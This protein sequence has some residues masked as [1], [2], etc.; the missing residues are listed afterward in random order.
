M[1]FDDKKLEFNKGVVSYFTHPQSIYNK[2]KANL[3][4]S[5]RLNYDDEGEKI[6]P[7]DQIID[8][9]DIASI[10]MVLQPIYD[11]YH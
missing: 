11:D 5:T 10:S 4:H 8:D 7:V 9:E 2:Y 1:I 6:I 3:S